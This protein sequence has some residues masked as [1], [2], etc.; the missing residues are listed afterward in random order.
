MAK[1]ADEFCV[2]AIAAIPELHGLAVIPVWNI[3]AENTPSGF[4][5]LRDPQ[6]PFTGSLMLML[7]QVTA[8]STNVNRE[9]LAQMQMLDRLAGELAAKISAH[10]QQLNEQQPPNG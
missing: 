7:A 9:L 1:R 3:K 10:A 2:A 6:P 5:R 4:M 8:F